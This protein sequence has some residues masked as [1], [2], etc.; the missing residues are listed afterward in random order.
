VRIL[1][2]QSTLRDR[3]PRER[4]RRLE[5]RHP[6]AVKRRQVRFSRSAWLLREEIATRKKAPSNAN[7]KP[8][9]EECQ[10][11]SASL[12]IAAPLEKR[13]VHYPLLND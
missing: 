7:R 5:L 4:N 3:W 8:R 11:M 9:L 2:S 10:N 13:R 6:A 1:P 12:L